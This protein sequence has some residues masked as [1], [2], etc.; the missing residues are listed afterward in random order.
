MANSLIEREMMAGKI[1]MIYMDP[2]YGVK[3]ASNFQARIDRRD[4]KDSDEHLTREPEM[5]KAYRDSWKL[6][7]ICI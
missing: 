4:V 2:P 7:F 6:G 1:Q 3:Y 5:I